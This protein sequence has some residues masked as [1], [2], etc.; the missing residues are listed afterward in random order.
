MKKALVVIAVASTL[1]LLLTGCFGQDPNQT[2]PID[3]QPPVPVGFWQN[4]T[5]V[6]WITNGT[7]CGEKQQ[8]L[9]EYILNDKVNNTEWKDTGKTRDNFSKLP[10]DGW[11]VTGLGN[12]YTREEEYRKHICFQGKCLY[13][14]TETR[15]Y[16][17]GAMI[18]EG[19]DRSRD[20]TV[21]RGDITEWYFVVEPVGNKT[22]D[23][24]FK[25]IAQGYDDLPILVTRDLK[26]IYSSG[27]TTVP[28]NYSIEI[29]MNSGTVNVYILD[30]IG[31]NELF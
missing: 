15:W 23:I 25:V 22:I 21:N 10:D 30:E 16:Q 3:E 29:I 28:E 18:L 24:S 14:V 8:V 1:V 9:R 19:I 20:V 7:C 2:I 31:Y 17:T 27:K 26:S 4:T 13:S 5:T 6:R 12:I 11:Y